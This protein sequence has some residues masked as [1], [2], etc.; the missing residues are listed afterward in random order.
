V[1]S[2]VTIRQA[3]SP[4]E[5]A[6]VR[7][8]VEAHARYERSETTLPPDWD[9]RTADLIEAARLVLFVA[10]AA[11]APVGYATL[12]HDVATWS[13]APYAHLDCLYVNDAHRDAG[14]G[15]LLIDA[16]VQCARDRG[17]SELQWQ[18]PAWNVAAVRFYDR[19]GARRQAKER[20]CLAV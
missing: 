19:L 8:L 4:L 13:A 15:R 9:S 3:T 16:A 20:F 11:G 6:T 1:S 14:I 2:A 10:V 17:Y 7:P 18:T 5:C 12:T